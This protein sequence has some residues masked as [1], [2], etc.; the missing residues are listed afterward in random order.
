MLQSFVNEI[1]KKQR[2]GLVLRFLLAL[3]KCNIVAN[4]QAVH[5]QK[6]L[7]EW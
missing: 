6:K 1:R 4:E 7:L 3:K 2:Q 5:A